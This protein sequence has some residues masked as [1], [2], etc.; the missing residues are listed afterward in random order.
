MY[1]VNYSMYEKIQNGN[2]DEEPWAE[3]EVDGYDSIEKAKSEA[4]EVIS[5]TLVAHKTPKTEV[6]VEARI[7][8]NESYADGDDFIVEFDGEKVLSVREV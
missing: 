5:K 3:C 4:V 2:F 7:E 1:K 8:C 6:L